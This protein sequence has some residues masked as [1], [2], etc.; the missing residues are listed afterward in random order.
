MESIN[1][2]KYFEAQVSRSQSG[3]QPDEPW[4]LDAHP[5]LFEHLLC[6]IRRPDIIPLF[7]DKTIGFDYDLYNTLGEKADFCGVSALAD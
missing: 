3:Q 4:F 5:D 2:S 7:W 6:F 1:E